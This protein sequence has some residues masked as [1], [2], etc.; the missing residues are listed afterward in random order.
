M[1]I[2]TKKLTPTKVELTLTAD[3]AQMDHAKS[4]TLHDLS[5]DVSL[6]GFR[7]GHAPEHLV[8]KSVDQ[9]LLQ[10]RFLDAV[11]NDMYGQAVI[12]EQLRVVAQPEVNVTKFVP[13]TEV[14]MKATV[15]IVGEVKLADYKKLHFTKQVEKTT[16]KD[17]ESVLQDLL[18]RDAE[19]KDVKRAAKD[20]D[21]VTID[22]K[23][24]DA[25]T[26]EAIAGA[27]GE[28]YPLVLGS[29]TFIPG[30][31]PELIG[32][33]A[34]E[35][36]TFDITF[37]KDYSAKELQNKKV[38]FTITIRGVKEV[39]KPALDDA[40]AAK[41]G[42]FKTVAE[43]KTDVRHQIE[44]EKD[45]QAQRKLESDSMEA[46]AEKS[47]VELPVVL[48]ED[49]MDRMEEEEKRN[50]M[51]RGQTWQEHLLAEGK[52]AEEHREGMREQATLRVKTGLVLGAVAQ[53]EKIDV[54]DEELTQRI[55]ELKKQYNDPQT[56]TELDKPENQRDI[57][58]RI[59]TEKT[60]AKLVT[61]VTK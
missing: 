54:N 19:K 1:Q 6:A 3:Q 25:K 14:E 40:F 37:P 35:E 31:E 11:I 38:T 21:E 60:I 32:L 15:E 4:R 18:A 22:F 57:A 53:A 55:A 9:T 30:F 44:A 17:V 36:K 59:L 61:Y 2:T 28:D 43:L 23:G 51:Y 16:D 56:H 33:K 12:E 8:E 52:T 26:K 24:V 42:P 34:G 47:K 50:L 49:E 27:E 7:K 29:N 10:N 41:I 13:F 5:K 39:V 45:T 20:G 46:L 58:S 48:I